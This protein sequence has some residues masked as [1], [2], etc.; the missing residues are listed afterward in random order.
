MLEWVHLISFTT[1][2]AMNRNTGI[3]ITVATVL[4]CGCPGLFSCFWGLLASVVSFIPGAEIDMAGSSDPMSALLAGLGGVC[5]G[6]IFIAIPIIVWLVTV[7]NK[8]A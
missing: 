4:L 8:P 7:R 3:I 6:I 2:S 5:V 1:E